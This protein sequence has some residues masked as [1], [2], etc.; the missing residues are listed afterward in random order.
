MVSGW[1]LQGAT[2]TDD[3]RMTGLCGELLGSCQ[4]LPDASRADGRLVQAFAEGQVGRLGLLQRDVAD[5]LRAE[6][7]DRLALEPLPDADPLDRAQAHF[8]SS[9]MR[10]TR[11]GSREELAGDCRVH[12]LYSPLGLRAALT[13][14]SRDR[15]SEVLVAAMFR[16]ASE[17]LVR[18]RFTDPGWDA[19]ARAHLGMPEPSTPSPGAT[20]GAAASSP[21]RPPSLMAS[22]FA[23]GSNERTELLAE[24]FADAANPAWD[25]LDRQPALAALGRYTTL[26]TTERREL[27]GAAT[28]AVWLA[29]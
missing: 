23:E 1:D 8:A 10:F 11:L 18:Y 15:Q 20:A 6:L 12:P 3:L 16:M 27:F 22:I 5:R 17:R 13:L 19:R 24:V 26:T 2:G 7:V 4:K 28:A 25:L 14:D 21:S 29:R 9:R